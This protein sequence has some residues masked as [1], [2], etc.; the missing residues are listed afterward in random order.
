ML[1]AQ[2]SDRVMAFLERP[3][4]PALDGGQAE[5]HRP[6]G[7]RVAPLARRQL[8]EFRARRAR[9]RR[10]CQKLPDHRKAQL[11]PSLVDPSLCHAGASLLWTGGR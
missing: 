9:R 7:H 6:A 11:R 2:D 3:V 10:R 5:A 1:A 4:I 8:V